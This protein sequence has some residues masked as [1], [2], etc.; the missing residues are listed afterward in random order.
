MPSEG[1][2]A[3][4]ADDFPRL[5]GFLISL[6]YEPGLA[7]DVAAETMLKTHER[8]QEIEQPRA[9]RDLDGVRRAVEGGWLSP[10]AGHDPTRIVEARLQREQ[11][12]K[13]LPDR[14]R[15]VMAWTFDDFEPTE[16]ADALGLPPETV[17]SNLRH[18]REKLKQLWIEQQ[19][20]TEGGV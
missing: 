14:Q 9:M 6:G 5:V 7:Q 13:A 11:L 12:L 18:A 16:I 3:F 4:F 19:Q 15:E 8:W 2:D 20:Q 17:R 1:F 10:V